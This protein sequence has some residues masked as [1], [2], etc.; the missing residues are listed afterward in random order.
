M[1][2]FLVLTDLYE[3]F[4]NGSCDPEKYRTTAQGEREEA[5]LCFPEISFLEIGSQSPG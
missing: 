4:F 3:K 1:I 2:A 5:E